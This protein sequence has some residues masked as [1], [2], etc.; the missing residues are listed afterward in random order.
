MIPL[1]HTTVWNTGDVRQIRRVID[2]P[3]ELRLEP[4]EFVL[5]CHNGYRTVGVLTG[6]TRRFWDISC[7]TLERYE[8]DTVVIDGAIWGVRGA[9]LPGTYAVRPERIAR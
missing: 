5:V 2:T 4:G 8:V 3:Q 1:T 7:P 6:R 9:R